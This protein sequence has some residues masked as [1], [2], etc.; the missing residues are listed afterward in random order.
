MFTPDV[1]DSESRMAAVL[2]VLISVPLLFYALSRVRAG[3]KPHLRPLPA[4]DVLSEVSGRAAESGRVLHVGL[5]MGG[6]S[7]PDAA[8][9]LAGLSAL[10]YLADQAAATEARLVVTV[11]DPTLL[12]AAQE[13]VRRA[14]ARRGR[15]DVFSASQVRLLAPEPA[16]YAAGVMGI[17]EGE[18]PLANVTIGAFGD[19][20]LLIGETGAKREVEQVAGTDDPAALAFMHVTAHETLIGEEIFAAGA[21]L[22]GDSKSVAGLMVQDWWRYL[23]VVFIIA[24]VL[25]QTLF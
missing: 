25:W 2:I 5:G 16:A 10:E 1:F 11:A 21:Y 17:L 20:Y 22:R 3:H 6:I 19:E 8:V 13:T 18:N 14:Y 9:S 12:P 15:S 24:A 23:V 4:F 7:G